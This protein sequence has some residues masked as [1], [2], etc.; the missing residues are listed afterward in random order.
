[1]VCVETEPILSICCLTFNHAPYL[2]RALDGIIM[3]KVDF[4]YEV[5]IG[6]DFSTDDSRKIINE[7]NLKYPNI[8][9]VIYREKNVGVRKN[10]EEVMGMANGKYVILLETDDYW[11]DPLKL[12]KQVDL[13]NS[14]PGIIAV[15]HPCKMVGAKDE[16]LPLEYPSIKKGFYSLKE[17][18]KDILPGQTAT[19]MYRNYHKFNILD[20][21]LTENPKRAKGPGDRRK[22]FMLASYGKIF[23]LPEEMSCYRFVK[24]QGSSF[25]ATNKFD[26]FNTI[27]YYKEF[28][29]YAKKNRL[30]EDSIYTAEALY[31]R[32][33][34][35]AFLHR[36]FQLVGLKKMIKEYIGINNKIKTTLFVVLFYF[37]EL[38]N[39]FKKTA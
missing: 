22:M 14:D 25:T 15:T 3:Q 1:M 5:I 28:V 13:L 33:L 2:R 17:Y 16:P 39:F 30:N 27:C 18:R 37:N 32:S 20:K 7:Y 31:M 24:N 35:I 38:R 29:D 12:Q 11:I 21:S 36:Q 6:D 23:A 26:F 19:M 9:K 34:W 4:I 10:L 8:F